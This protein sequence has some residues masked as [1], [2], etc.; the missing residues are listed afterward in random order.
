MTTKL[1]LQKDD[2][3]V[4][5]LT[6]LHQSRSVNMLRDGDVVEWAAG[7]LSM[8]YTFWLDGKHIS[9]AQVIKLIKI[10]TISTAI[11]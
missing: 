1:K 2:N 3:L 10:V 5:I 8:R 6:G 7:L 9:P 11:M 4:F